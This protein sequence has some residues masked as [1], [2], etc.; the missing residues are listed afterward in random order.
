MAPA[1]DDG[2]EVAASKPQSP[3]RITHD[4]EF[5]ARLLTKESSQGN[6]SFRYYGAGTGAV[7]FVWESHPG[8]P[9]VDASSCRVLAAA[10]ADVPAITPLPSYHLRAASVSSHGGHSGRIKGGGGGSSKYCG[11]YDKLKWIKIGFIV[12][13]FRRLSVGKSRASSV[14]PS[15]STRW[16]F[17]GTSDDVETGDGA[18]HHYHEAPAPGPKTKG[19]HLL[20]LGVRPSPWIQFCGA[21]S[22]RKFDTGSSH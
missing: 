4:G 8:T 7:P 9:K 16:L 13:V 14:Q 17:S 20:C 11:Y 18:Q 6:P 1:A 21:R 3:L 2:A 12:A 5:Y 19:L 10:A 15:P 22:C